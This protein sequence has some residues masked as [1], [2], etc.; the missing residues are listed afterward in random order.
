M[1]KFWNN[2]DKKISPNFIEVESDSDEEIKKIEK[3]L[4]YPIMIKPTNM[5]SSKM[6]TKNY[7]REE[8][9]KSLTSIFNKGGFIQSLRKTI[10]PSEDKIE[11]IAEEFME[12]SMYSVDGVI[13]DKDK[14]SMYPPVYIKTGKS[15]GFD[16]FFGYMQ[17][18]PSKI[19]SE[20]RKKMNKVIKK[21]IAG[22]SLDN[23][24]FHIELFKTEDYEWRVIEIAPRI[25]GFREF[26][27][28]NTYG[29]SV[30]KNNILNKIGSK[31]EYDEKVKNPSA[32]LKIYAKSEGRIKKILGLKKVEALDSFVKINKKKK[33]GDMAKFAKN[34]A[35]PVLIIYLK[36]KKR[37][38]LLGD[39][40]KIEEIVKIII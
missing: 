37:G 24:H 13:D 27:Y 14:V 19:S 26:L 33:V 39:V 34:G 36:N 8:L 11:V 15:I 10:L 20:N 17:I 4:E 16:D 1:R 12:G 9:K 40:R 32:V 25:G 35:D 2:Y 29:F 6:V 18:L 5:A 23:S 31:I 38:S 30:N 28:K 7:H 22:L 3:N 21:A